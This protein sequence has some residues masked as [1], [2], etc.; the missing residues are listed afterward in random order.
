MWG[1]GENAQHFLLLPTMFSKDR[2]L[3]VVKSRDCLVNKE[4]NSRRDRMT[5]TAT[6][7]ISLS[8]LKVVSTLAIWESSQWLGENMWEVAVNE[9]PGK[10]GHMYT[11]PLC[12][13]EFIVK[14]RY[15]GVRSWDENGTK[16]LKNHPYTPKAFSF[17][18]PQ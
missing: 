10:H 8:Q 9:T 4:F 5:I 6:G 12:N 14:W 2:F 15:S 17:I 13:H 18:K 1:K 11:K 7:F 3:R 16:I